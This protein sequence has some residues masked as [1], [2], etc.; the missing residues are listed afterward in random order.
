MKH[1]A[2]WCAA[3][4]IAALGTGY[5]GRARA[6]DPAPLPAGIHLAPNGRYYQDVCDHSLPSYCLSRRLLPVDFDPQVARP[7]KPRP[8]FGG[9]F[10]QPM[11][12]GG[13]GASPPAGSMTPGDIVAA[14]AL[15]AS[16]GAHGQIVALIDMPDSAAFADLTTY[17]AQFD[18]PALPRCTSGLPDGKTPCFAQVDATGTPNF[19][20]LDCPGADP[21]T[22]L[23]MEMLSAACPDC[24]ILVVQMTNATNGPSYTDF[25]QAVQTAA[26]LGAVATSISF[27][28]PEQGGESTGFTTPGHLVL[29][30]SGD[31]GYLNVLVPQIGGQSPS[32]PASAPDV[33]GVGG[34]ELVALGGGTYGEKVWNDGQGG[35]GGSGCST[36]FP[37]PGFQSAFLASHAGAFGACKN[38]DSVD[39]S[40]A[41]EFATGSQG[42]AG[43]AEFDAQ[44]RWGAV[45]GTSAASPM[46][47]GI[48]TRLGLA[49]T[50][51]MDLGFP[52]VNAEAFHDVTVGDNLVGNTCPD[53][54]C[55]AG[56]GWDG[57]TGVGTPDG[58]KL[59]LLGGGSSS[60]GS[61]GGSGSGAGPDGGSGAA[62]TTARAGCGCATIGTARSLD[63]LALLAAGAGAVVVVRRR[64]SRFASNGPVRALPPSCR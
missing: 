64:R 17:R 8:L 62:D 56:V 42:E 39:V 10:C 1:S 52:Y 35:A 63:A 38:R 5:E 41:A 24:S 60:G 23:D 31:A 50:L 44:D 13:G 53:M 4:A 7:R 2:R 25:T 30:A 34:T 3:L 43:I 46:V 20:S 9:Q 14:Y 47:A 55:M 16:S 12:A 18:L 40:A 11:Q 36:E 54:N 27:G 49:A 19:T 57:P 28:I 61:S 32:Y 51:S 48:F 29:A 15:P 37:M 26:H 45:V 59:A 6:S 22:G 21:E 58:A 33:L